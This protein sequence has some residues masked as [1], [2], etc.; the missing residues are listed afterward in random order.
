MAC[1]SIPISFLEAAQTS[2][3]VT[4]LYVGCLYLPFTNGPRDEPHIIRSRLATLSFLSIFFE[5]YTRERIPIA[6][7]STLLPKPSAVLAGTALTLMLYS[8]HLVV[9]PLRS[10]LRHPPQDRRHTYRALR[11]YLLGPFL[12]ELCFRRHLVLLWSCHSPRSRVLFPAIFFAL[13]HIHHTISLGLSPMLFQFAFTF[14]FGVY[15]SVL[16]TSTHSIWAPFAAHVVCNVLEIPCFEAI[17]SHPRRRL[18]FSFYVAAL[19]AFAMMFAPIT[20][21]VRPPITA[22]Q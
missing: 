18:I 12:E 2:I 22:S 8:G 5:W 13:A 19:I 21:F 3:L 14:L 16:Y 17:S 9:T 7:A 15:A 20:D 6:Q 10:V 4:C 11:N 1:P